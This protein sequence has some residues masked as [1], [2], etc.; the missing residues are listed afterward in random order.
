MN[1]SPKVWWPPLFTF[2]FIASLACC[3]PKKAFLF[4]ANPSP[5]DRKPRPAASFATIS[6]EDARRLLAAA[7]TSWHIRTE[8]TGE[9]VAQ[10]WQEDVFGG[11]MPLADHSLACDG[12][13]DALSGVKPAG[14]AFPPP[15]RYSPP[16]M[17]AP[18]AAEAENF[19][20][21]ASPDSEK[22]FPK[23]VLL[24]ISGLNI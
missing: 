8:N 20:A 15:G 13:W 21:E 12:G 7:R 5:A 9:A 16:S 18:E 11:E 14:G 23:S 6:D 19:P 17:A 1:P 10:I 2:A 22:A 24:D 3:F 4:S